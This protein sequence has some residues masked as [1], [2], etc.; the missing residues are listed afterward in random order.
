VQVAHA[1]AEVPVVVGEVL[2]HALGERGDQH[3]LAPVD[4]AADFAEQVVDLAGRGPDV[5]PRV[6]REN[7]SVSS[8]P[9][10]ARAWPTSRR[11]AI[12]AVS[13]MFPV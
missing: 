4:P 5:D 8:F 9:V 11:S 3:P 13:P 7:K 6:D 1:D 2:G 12:L 10:P